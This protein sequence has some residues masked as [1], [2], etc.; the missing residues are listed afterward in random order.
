MLTV[1]RRGPDGRFRAPV[2][3]GVIHEPPKDAPKVT[4]RV[5]DGQPDP[6]YHFAKG[7]IHQE[8]ASLDSLLITSV[9]NG[10]S[11]SA[12]ERVITDDFRLIRLKQPPYTTDDEIRRVL[13]EDDGAY[14]ATLKVAYSCAS[15]DLAY[16][17]G[18]TRNINPETGTPNEQL[19]GYTRIWRRDSAG[20]WK[21][22][23]E[24]VL[25]FPYR[26]AQP[27]PQPQ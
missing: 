2:Q 15:D 24:F 17:Y 4:Y 6:D 25:R 11:V 23:F 12:Y 20:E 5:N 27:Q 3:I 10:K 9:M 8:I 18:T 26:E 13:A 19:G 22:A 21:L 7:Q 16:S 14:K 1:Y